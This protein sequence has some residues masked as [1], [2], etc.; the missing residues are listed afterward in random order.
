MVMI[1]LLPN[2]FPLLVRFP[3]ARPYINIS[4]VGAPADLISS[5]KNFAVSIEVAPPL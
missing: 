5:Q 3:R 1:Y 2:H 4:G